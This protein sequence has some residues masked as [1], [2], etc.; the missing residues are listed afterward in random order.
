MEAF[1]CKHV[2]VNVNHVACA[3]LTIHVYFYLIMCCISQIFP[4]GRKRGIHM[5]WKI[6]TTKK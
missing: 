1:F 5:I 4:H 2:V 6:S 3:L